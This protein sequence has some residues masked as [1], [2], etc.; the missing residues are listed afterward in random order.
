M[1]NV[2]NQ[3]ISDFAHANRLVNQESRLVSNWL[4]CLL[5]NTHST[6]EFFRCFF[7][8][9]IQRLWIPKQVY[10]A[11]VKRKHINMQH[12]HTHIDT[13]H[14]IFEGV[15]YPK[16]STALN[17]ENPYNL[18]QMIPFQRFRISQFPRTINFEQRIF[19]IFHS[20]NSIASCVWSIFQIGR[21]YIRFTASTSNRFKGL[22]DSNIATDV[23]CFGYIEWWKLMRNASDAQTT[24]PFSYQAKT[25]RIECC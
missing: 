12:T 2:T 5:F 3:I 18:H 13:N 15:Y 20:L 19:A 21:F 22:F 9:T 11:S 14:S 16:H 24:S 8:K 6:C 1:K 17:E 25:Y 4:E 7:P 23:I 10:L